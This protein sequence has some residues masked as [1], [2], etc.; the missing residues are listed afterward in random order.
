MRKL[1]FQRTDK[2]GNILPPEVKGLRYHWSEHPLYTREWYEWKIKG[3]TPEKIAQEL[4]IDYNTAVV[5]RVYPEFPKEPSK[6]EYN[7]RKPMYVWI[8]NSHG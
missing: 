5:G 4:E 8:D 7:P 2:D 6:V 3:M 1:A